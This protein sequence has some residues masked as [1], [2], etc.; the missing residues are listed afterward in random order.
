MP[1]FRYRALTPD[2]A[3][4]AGQIEAGTAQAARQLLRHQGLL[5]V[6]LALAHPEPGKGNPQGS[7][8][9]ATHA[10]RLSGQTLTLITRQMAT[11]LRAGLRIEE[12]LFTIAG[13]Q[14]QKSAA[15]LQGL[16]GAVLEGQSLSAALQRYPRCFSGFYVAS[17]RAGEQAGRLAQVMDHLAGF[18]ENRTRN[19][20]TVQL[21]LLY[22]ALLGLVSLGIVLLL[23]IF[24]VPDI[25][26]VFQDRGADLPTLTRLLIAVSHGAQTWGAGM[27]AL[28]VLLVLV[29]AQWA[30]KDRNLLKLHLVLAETRPTRNLV[31]RMT[32]AQVAGT[33]ATLLISRVPLVEALQAAAAVTPNLHIRAT[34]ATA[35]E[36]VRQGMSLHRAMQEAACFPPMMLAMIASGEAAGD[37]G[38][39]LQHSAIEQQRD[40]DA[41][42]R[43]AVALVEPAVLL[44]M[45]G[46]VMAMVLAIL[47]PIISLNGL[48]AG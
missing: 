20:Q 25:V 19:R 29:L 36:K 12:A 6:E 39:A 4:R 28:M 2:G 44:V 16:R 14:P 23:L 32:A 30:R 10:A 47:L 21:A 26:K 9:N 46:V 31:R 41:W 17:V 40:L 5:P 11:L 42:V 1:A 18:I 22:P 37:L 13:G 33:L 38:Q 45:G 7:D 48:A 35:T 15:V 27:L 8:G 43:A 24:V 34:L 3:A